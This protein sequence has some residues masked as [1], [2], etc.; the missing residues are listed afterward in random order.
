MSNVFVGRPEYQTS[1]F[2]RNQGCSFSHAP[3]PPPTSTSRIE[4]MLEA[5]YNLQ[6][7]SGNQQQILEMALMT[8]CH[9]V[10]TE[11]EDE[12]VEVE[13]RSA[14]FVIDHS[15]GT[16]SVDRH[17][18]ET[19]EESM[20]DEAESEESTPEISVDRHS[21]SVDRHWTR[22]TPYAIVFPPHAIVLR[23]QSKRY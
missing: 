13:E 2:T 21:P 6:L 7:R 11:H 4:A 3:P 8:A 19:E 10:L 12:L 18:S 1:S 20:Y 23:S 15:T 5:I 14:N 9:A 17:S 22:T 16:L